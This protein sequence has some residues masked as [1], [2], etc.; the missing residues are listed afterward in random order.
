[1]RY[2]MAK[3][4]QEQRDHT[5][6]MFVTE[7]LRLQGEGKYITCKYNDLVKPRNEDD[8]QEVIEE[9]FENL[10]LRFGGE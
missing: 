10:N 9:V 2:V 5:Y 6:R 4:E 1:M 8:G 3:A 7:S